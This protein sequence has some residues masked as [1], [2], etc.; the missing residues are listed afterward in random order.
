MPGIKVLSGQKLINIFLLFGFE[1][2]G[3]KGS[4]V[5]LVRYFNQKQECLVVPKH[6]ELDRGTTKAIY[7]QALQ[8][9]SESE[10]EPHFY[11]K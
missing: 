6:R 1:V 4:H 3:Q 5:K 2:S 9:I 7:N 11:N 10:L 8:Y